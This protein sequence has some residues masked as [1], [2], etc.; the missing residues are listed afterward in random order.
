VLQPIHTLLLSVDWILIDRVSRI[1]RF[2][3]AWDGMEKRE[4]DLLTQ[5]KVM[6]TIQSVSASTRIEGSLMSDAEVDTLLHGLDT[7]QLE[8]HDSR[9][10]AGY[11]HVL[12]LINESP[13]ALLITE[14][15]I[16][17]LHQILLKYNPDDAW[18]RGDY[19][20]QSNA[21]QATMAD[22]TQQDILRTTP[23]GF[24]TD[25]GMRSLVEWYAKDGL[26]HPI[27]KTAI[28]SYEFVTIHPFQDGNGRMSRLLIILLLLQ[29]GYT[30]IQ[31]VSVE[32]EIESRKAEYYRVLRE[33]QVSRPEEDVTPWVAF[34]LDVLLT[35][36]QRLLR[37]LQ[38]QGNL[39]ILSSKERKIYLFVENHPGTQSGEIADRLKVPS[40]TVKRLLSRMVD[41]ELL[42]RSGAGRTTC[43]SIN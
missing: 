33:C 29:H 12:D 2:D 24:T 42:R 30:W 26:T 11:Y 6:A 3:G 37:K 4:G 16:K 38:K 32:Q 7:T 14:S 18:H 40:P 41:R 36:Q 15:T 43:Y 39:G 10:V 20:T 23:H 1:D 17:H 8:D 19:K 34:F 9:D 21:V 28:L 27:I 31:F 35:I 13:E 25:D 5:L 22:G